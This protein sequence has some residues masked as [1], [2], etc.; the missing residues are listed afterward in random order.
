M[1][2][3]ELCKRNS[4]DALTQ[5]LNDVNLHPLQCIDVLKM[6]A[7]KRSLVIYDTG[8]GKTLLAALAMKLL[9]R[10]DP[11]RLFVMFVKKDQIVQTPNKL[12]ALAGLSTLVTTANS[13]KIAKYFLNKNLEEY[14]VIMLTH[15][16]LHNSIVLQAIYEIR[17]RVASIIIDEAHELNN[18]NNASSAEILKAMISR[19]EYVWGLTATPIVSDLMQ[20]A[21]LANLINPQQY[22]NAGKL[23]KS[24]TNGS[25]HI[26][27]D[28]GFF[29]NRK[30]YELGRYSSPNGFIVTVQPRAEQINCKLGGVELFQVC[31]GDG[32]INQV[33]ALIELIQVN[34]KAGKRGLIFISQHSVLAWVRSNLDETAIQY[35]CINGNTSMD[36]RNVIEAEFADKKYDVILTSVTTAV[37]LDCEYVAFY[38]FTVMVSQMIGRAHRGLKPKTL[39]VYFIITQNTNEEIYFL[40]NIYDKCQIVKE[41]LGKGNSAVENVAAH[42]GVIC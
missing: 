19:F 13:V 9:L 18:F 30:A 34:K 16:C 27:Y 20:L 36:A 8:T 21:R 5:F 4:Y 28:P 22:P 25:F 39:D 14:N 15:D 23:Y 6:I 38:E 26:D 1:L 37:D 3:D 12:K 7:N 42:L 2:I 35:T 17:E 41:I 29:I 32:A 24:L 11:S 40:N 10:E 31:K 33:N